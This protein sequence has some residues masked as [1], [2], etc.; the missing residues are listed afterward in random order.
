MTS[1][2]PTG[3]SPHLFVL[4]TERAVEFYREA[5]GAV[6]VF[7][8]TLP[9]GVILFVELQVGAGRLLVSEETPELGAL[10]PPTVGGSPVMILLE[11]D[12]PDAVARSAIDAGAEVLMPVQEMFW[13][14]RYGVLRDP[15]GHRWSVT[16][17]REQLTPDEIVRNTGY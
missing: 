3:L 2:R 6:E 8:N 17:A 7:R 11:V 1:I 5:F 14:E 4:G 9:N 13:G 16:T 10:A 12:D 15:F